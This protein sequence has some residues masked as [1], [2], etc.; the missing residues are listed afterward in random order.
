MRPELIEAAQWVRANIS[1]L[2]NE[3]QPL[4]HPLG[5]VSCIVSTDVSGNVFRLHYW[6]QNERRPKKPDW[7]IHTHLFDLSSLVLAGSIRDKQYRTI[8]GTQFQPFEVEYVGE[9]SSIRQSGDTVD[10]LAISESE[11]L[12]HSCYS[13]ASGVFHESY[14]QMETEAATLV[15]CKNHSKKPPIVL[16]PTAEFLAEVVKKFSY[17]RFPYDPIIFWRRISETLD[18]FL[19]NEKVVGR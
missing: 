2:S 14:V 3:V 16:G 11:L 8:A 4:W 1:S 9:D 17:D 15:C 18:I 6:P 13:V 12:P 5:F 19:S 10:I 7:P